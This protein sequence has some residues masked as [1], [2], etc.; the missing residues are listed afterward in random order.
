M[1]SSGS[2]SVTVPP[3]G[4]RSTTRSAHRYQHQAPWCLNSLPTSPGAA[5]RVRR[6][7]A[8]LATLGRGTDVC[9]V[10]SRRME[11]CAKQQGPPA[12]AGH[13]DPS[14]PPQLSPFRRG[15]NRRR[16]TVLVMAGP[17]YFT[18]V[19][20]EVDA[21]CTWTPRVKELSPQGQGDLAL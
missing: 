5:R 19:T 14:P 17:H 20:V 4:R 13:T 21:S 6:P 15:S 8:P 11:R 18:L 16:R 12:A 9:K 3:P 7:A 10:M 2:F 1:D